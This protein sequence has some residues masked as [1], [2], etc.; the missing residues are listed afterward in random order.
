MYTWSQRFEVIAVNN[1]LQMYGL[2]S[3]GIVLFVL[4]MQLM[5]HYAALLATGL[6]MMQPVRLIFNFG[7][8]GY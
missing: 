8:D 1:T 5:S 7:C 3:V 4:C 2:P 6:R